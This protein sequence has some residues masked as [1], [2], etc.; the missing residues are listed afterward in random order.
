MQNKCISPDAVHFR[1]LISSTCISQDVKEIYSTS[2]GHVPP[3]DAK[4][5][6]LLSV[7]FCHWLSGQS[8]TSL[9]SHS[10]SLKHSQSPLAWIV[11]VSKTENHWK[12]KLCRSYKLHSFNCKEDFSFRSRRNFAIDFLFVASI[13]L[14]DKMWKQ[15]TAKWSWQINILAINLKTS[16]HTSVFYMYN[17]HM[18]IF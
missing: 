2:W 6:N 15:V 3:E 12:V 16:T 17:V 14:F 18:L 9:L 5:V 8:F 11:R 10:P 7:I 1:T 4:K 13:K